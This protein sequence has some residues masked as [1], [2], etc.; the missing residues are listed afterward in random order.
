MLGAWT[1]LASASVCLV[2]A[3]SASLTSR[4]SPCPMVD[5]HAVPDS[6]FTR[7]MIHCGLMLGVRCPTEHPAHGPPAQAQASSG[8][9]S[10]QSSHYRRSRLACHA[11]HLHTMPPRPSC[12]P[13]CRASL[14]VLISP[15]AQGDAGYDQYGL[16]TST[17]TTETNPNDRNSGNN[18]PTTV[19]D[20]Q[21]TIIIATYPVGGPDLYPDLS[22][23][24]IDAFTSAI[25]ALLRGVDLGCSCEFQDVQ[26]LTRRRSLLVS[27]DML[28]GCWD[29]APLDC[30][31]G[32]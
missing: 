24:Y 3:P 14:A 6:C 2:W 30:M 17:D 13:A 9:W 11:H 20:G 1:S 31:S 10:C 22:E 4:E 23:D 27:H 26:L 7:S 21:N 16:G 19:T 28:A 5:V 32:A 8:L 12:Q 25:L 29:V 18:L 15:Q